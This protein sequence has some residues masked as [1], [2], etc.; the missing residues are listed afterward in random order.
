MF[1]KT[2][3]DSGITVV[4]E[5]HR[6]QRSVCVGAFIGIGT[7]DESLKNV[8]ICHFVEHMV[9]K[10]T[11]NR[12]TNEIARAI[13]EVGGDLN[14]FTTR[15]YT[16]FHTLSLKDDL[17]LDIE[18][19]GDL[20]VNARFNQRDFDLEKKVVLQ[21]VSMTEDTPEEYIFDLFF[22]KIYG[23]AS[24]GWPI[25]GTKESLEALKRSDLMKFYK[26][27]YCGKN[28]I[29]AAAGAL[30]HD[31]VVEMVEKSFHLGKRSSKKITKLPQRKK[32]RWVPVREVIRKEG[33]QTHILVGFEGVSFTSP[34]RF[35]AFVL[36][37]WMGGGMS[38]KLYQSIREKKG[39]AY[40]VYSNL[41]TFTDCGTL[42][43]YA[44]TE[45]K[46]VAAVM[47]AIHHDIKDL[48]R[49]KL[50]PRSLEL[51]KQ[52]VRGGILLGADDMENR[53]S[54]LG[55]NEMTFGEYMAVDTV[56]EGIDKVTASDVRALAH[57]LLNPDKMAVLVMGDVDTA[58]TK[59]AIS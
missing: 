24:L 26:E 20:V 57:E 50:N 22:E 21:E 27:R 19:L 11:K 5:A 59:K 55:V 44:A 34:K 7:R 15:E 37:A 56:V 43:I 25:L 39:L 18:V 41:T 45:G 54:S 32:P 14:A 46:S 42:S 8:G 47:E 58:K 33:E 1:K 13:E 4:T 48:K 40:T 52:Q 38:S 2:V 23:K 29:V 35:E 3:L 53:M 30:D 10:G 28:I 51:F 36:N 12:S 31:T 49:K 16:C 6:Y 17:E 9:F